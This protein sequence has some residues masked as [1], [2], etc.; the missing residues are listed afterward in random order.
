MY[1]KIMSAAT[2]A[3]SVFALLKPRHLGVALTKSPLTQQEYDIVA[4]TFGA[5][6]L[7]VS[8]LAIVA[9]STAAREQ[10]MFARIFLDLSDASMLTPQARS[11]SAKAKVL[12]ATL[13]WAGLNIAAVV[14]DRRRS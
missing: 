13:T 1:S 10:A 3:Y 5:R 9:P 7:A 4:R 6:D 11:A 2:A 14:A 8:A 12:G